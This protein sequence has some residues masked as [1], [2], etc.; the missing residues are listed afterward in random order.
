MA[1]ITEKMT[2][3]EYHKRPELNSSKLAAFY[4]GPDYALM[5]VIPK[6]TWEFGHVFETF[7]QGQAEGS[8]I[9]DDRYFVGRG[10]KG[11]I[12]EVLLYA[13]NSGADLSDLYVYTAKGALN[14]TKQRLHTWL[15]AQK[16]NIGKMPV[17]VDDFER[18]QRMTENLFKTPFQGRKIRDFFERAK[19]QVPI[20]WKAQGIEKRALIDLLVEENDVVELIG[21]L[22]STASIGKFI[23]AARDRLWIQDLHYTEGIQSK[24]SG[25]VELWDTLY[26]FPVI[27]VEPWVAIEPLM[28]SYK[29]QYAKGENAAE[30]M[31]QKY[32]N[33]CEDYRMWELAGKPARG[34]VD[35]GKVSVW[36]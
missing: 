20:F 28:L 22:K 34:Y 25:C 14:K 19:W 29:D 9:F 35:I 24:D 32:Q 36:V 5:E 13:I 17:S 31:K 26:F 7:V 23:G 30:L 15:D 21:D 10:L 16:E 11:S 6:P 18:A 8:T 12:P 33:L 27:N 3:A 1:E 2:E 4:A